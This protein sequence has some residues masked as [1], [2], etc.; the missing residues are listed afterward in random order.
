MA[1]LKHFAVKNADYGAAIDYLK[2]QHDEFHLVPILDENGNSMFREEFYLEGMNCNPEAFDLECEMLNEQ[3]HKNKLYNEIK[4]HHYIISHDPRDVADHG[5]TGE[6]A[7]AI[8]MEYAKANFPGHQA[9]VCTHTDGNNNSGNIH[10][11]IIINSLRKEDIAPQPYTKRAIDRKAG[12]KHHLTKEYL[13]H[14]QGSLMDICQREGLYQVDL[15][16]PAA[17]KITQQEYHAQ[18]RGQLNLDMAN[19]EIM[20]EGIA[21]MKTKFETNKEKIRN[22]INDIA[23][24]AKSFE[25]FQRLLKAEYGILVKDHR[26]RFSYLP[27][28][29]KKYITARQLGSHYDR[30]YL[31]QLFEENA[32]ATEQN[33]VQWVQDD[34][35]TI[36]FIKSD[37]RL[38]LDLQNCIKAQQSR[39]YAQKVKIS[40]L[41][42]MAKTVAY[43]QEHGYDTQ[44]KLQDTTDTIQSKMAKARSDAKLTEAK[45]KKV[46]EQIHYLGQYLSTKSVYTHFLK[47]SNKSVFRHS[48]ADEIA[49]YE[50]ALQFLKQSSPDGK[51]PTMKD[52]RSEKE[53][54]IQQKSAQYETYQYFK[55]YHRE[56]QTVC[57]N[58]NHILDTSQTK[59]Q[60]QKKSHQ[61]EHS[62]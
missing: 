49:K 22:A 44:E 13:R 50:E 37:L 48:H 29:W 11:H 18:R 4:C 45:L 25:E 30:E 47:S 62:L 59:Q 28:D 35:I 3:F 60:E 31:L 46:N 12:Y 2:Y 56:L 20:A 27:S 58:V 33:Q 36:L 38:V 7:Q 43:I 54:L 6:Q 1:I 41:Q 34:P 39:A 24:R 19:M 55:D 10:T 61:S 53:L 32:L 52:L 40:N 17:D 42:Q 5:L 26:G 15:L 23:E 9:L 16:S 14:L 21:P 57:E 51:L 8:G